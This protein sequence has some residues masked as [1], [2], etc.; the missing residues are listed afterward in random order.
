MKT[1]MLI[2]AALAFAGAGARAEFDQANAAF[3]EKRYQEA[4]GQ[5][6]ATLREQGYSVVTLFNLANAYYHEGK[7]GLAILNYERAQL[8]APRIYDIAHNLSIARLKAGIVDRPAHFL[9][10][11]ELSWLGSAALLCFGATALFRRITVRRGTVW[12][13]ASGCVLVAAMIALLLRYPEH[14]RAIVV[15]KSAPAYIAP[16]TVTQ[17]LFTLTEGQPVSIRKVNGDFL[18][19]DAGN[20]R[21]CWV[22]PSMVERVTPM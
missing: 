8:L 2:L 5:Y 4:A 13:V 11:N 6:E 20:S 14:G 19:V 12:A 22:T 21:R 15:A 3:A 7:L 16:V 10:D 1:S 17:P 18:L 9:S